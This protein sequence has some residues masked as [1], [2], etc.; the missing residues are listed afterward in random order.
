MDALTLGAVQAA[1]VVV[2]PRGR[3]A[4]F[5]D[6]VPAA[7]IALEADELGLVGEVQAARL[8]RQFAIQRQL[9]QALLRRGV[10]NAGG[11]IGM[12]VEAGGKGIAAP[13]Q[14]AALIEEVRLADAQIR[15]QVLE[16]VRIAE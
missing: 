14:G 13:A 12:H 15:M 7:Q 8:E 3:G 6:E 4:I 5:L 2:I 16:I 11:L 1:Y 9:R 10:D